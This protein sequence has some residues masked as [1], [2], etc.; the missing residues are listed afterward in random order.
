MYKN[1]KSLKRGQGVRVSYSSI[2]HTPSFTDRLFTFTDIVEGDD[3]KKITEQDDPSDG[4]EEAP[5]LAAA[6]KPALAAAAKPALAAAAAKPAPVA[7]ARV[8]TMHKKDSAKP[9]VSSCQALYKK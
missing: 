2:H 6:A 3:D 7:L 1:N 8:N 5:A 9:L 4:T